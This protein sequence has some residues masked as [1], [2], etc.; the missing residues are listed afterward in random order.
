MKNSCRLKHVFPALSHI[1]GLITS[2]FL[3]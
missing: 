1:R 2:S 3:M